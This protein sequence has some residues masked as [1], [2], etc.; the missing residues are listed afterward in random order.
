MAAFHD[1]LAMDAKLLQ[2]DRRL[3]Y[4]VS[5]VV[6][7][8]GENAGG[9]RLADPANASQHI[10]LRDASAFEG[11]GQGLDHR[12]L[13]DHQVIEI[14]RPIFAREDP[15]AISAPQCPCRCRSWPVAFEFRPATGFGR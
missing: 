10:G 9:G 8:A 7:G 15:V 14:L 11:I 12:L 3:V 5:L 13:A 4:R 1:R 6:E 2:L